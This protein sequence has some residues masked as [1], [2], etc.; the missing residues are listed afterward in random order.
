MSVVLLAG[1][2]ASI[3][4]G[5]AAAT[6]VSL[7]EPLRA[8]QILRRW[9]IAA[10]AYAAILVAAAALPRDAH[11]P[12]C[13]DDLCMNVE[14]VSRTPLPNGEIACRLDIR[15]FSLANRGK[16]SARGALVY[17]TDERGRRFPL[18][19]DPAA[20]PFDVDLSP[21]ESVATTLTFPV[22]ADAKELFFNGRV[23]GIRYASFII[24]NGDLLN[25]PRLRFRVP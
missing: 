3:F 21:R 13:D 16:R 23:P 17:L 10:A 6:F 11:A 8:R 12:Y 18:A 25:Q 14:R 24:G 5:V 19:Q 7:G 22:P 2:L 4:C 15:I 1:L 20:I 9:A